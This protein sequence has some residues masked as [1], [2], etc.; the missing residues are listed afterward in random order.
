MCL[1]NFRTVENQLSF[2]HR[3][4]PLELTAESFGLSADE[5]LC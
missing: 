4:N 1:K 5:G 2:G 3:Q